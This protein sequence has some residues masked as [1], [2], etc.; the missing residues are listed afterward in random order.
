MEMNQASNPCVLLLNDIHIS[1]DNIPAFKANWNEALGICQELGIH[2]VVFGGD[3]FLSRVSQTLDVLLA[4]NDALENAHEAGISVT[5]AEGNHDLVD[6]EALR[7][8]C[9]IYAHHPSVAVVDDFLTIDLQGAA[10]VLHVM[11]YFPENGSFT[12]K[13]NALI[14]G[15]LHE[16]RLNYLYI[17]EGI[18]G[19]LAQPSVDELPAHIFEPFDRVFVGHYHNRVK[20]PGTKIEYIGSSRQHNFGE[21]IAKG[22]TILFEDGS[23]EFIVNRA[24]T[25]Y[26]VFDVSVEKVDI[27]LFDL[28]D[29]LRAE[30]NNRVKVRVHGDETALAGVDR[31]KLLE[32]GAAKV[33][34][35]AAVPGQVEAPEMDVLEKFDSRKI[36]ESYA[37]FCSRKQIENI[38]LGLSYLSKIDTPCGN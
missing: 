12:D 28:L 11:S 27:N 1:K 34:V 24:N 17:H 16:D 8:Y 36:R 14:Q 19:A 4:V 22:Y 26:L 35:V 31:K 6:Q 18:N 30:G 3:M 20:I 32:A 38:D 2:H 7:G 21:D 9:H 10:F 29:G 33:E 15:G 13:L 23:S 37:D 25:H 5:L